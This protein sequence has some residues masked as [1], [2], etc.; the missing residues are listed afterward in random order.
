MRY[1]HD[2]GDS[3]MHACHHSYRGEVQTICRGTRDVYVR[4]LQLE[5]PYTFYSTRTVALEN[6]RASFV[7]V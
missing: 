1:Q 4:R 6:A 3:Y 5:F 2:M 7:V